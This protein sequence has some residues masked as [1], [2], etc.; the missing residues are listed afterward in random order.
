MI[1]DF[2]KNENVIS[3]PTWMIFPLYVEAVPRFVG[4]TSTP[5][6]CNRSLGYDRRILL[7]VDVKVH[8]QCIEHVSESEL[9]EGM[10]EDRGYSYG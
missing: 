4:A 3:S 7:F 5:P 8:V 2:H 1:F 10:E 6:H 9:V